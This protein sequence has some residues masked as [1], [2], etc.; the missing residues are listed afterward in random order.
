[1]LKIPP[2]AGERGNKGG[3][4]FKMSSSLDSQES[5]S[6]LRILATKVEKNLK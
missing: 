5:F 3:E 4:V 2:E 6:Y 1:M